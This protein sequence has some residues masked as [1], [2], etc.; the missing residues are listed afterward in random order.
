MRIP[1]PRRRRVRPEDRAPV[2]AVPSIPDGG[3]PTGWPLTNSAP[4]LGD[5][6][7]HGA[8]VGY[9]HLY[10]LLSAHAI[11][12]SDGV[13]AASRMLTTAQIAKA[14]TA[15]GYF[16][17]PDLA[18]AMADVPLAASSPVSA[19]VFDAMYRRRYATTDTVVA[20]VRAKIAIRPHE[21]P[22]DNF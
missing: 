8:A 19:T 17:L 13:T 18:A 10:W 14:S 2:A 11:L 12:K 4:R 1:F 22:H 6:S 21:F 9:G 3:R 7:P 5:Q 16:D 15:C 20:A